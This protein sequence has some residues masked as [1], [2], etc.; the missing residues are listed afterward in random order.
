MALWASAQEYFRT[1]PVSDRIKTLQVGVDGEKLSLPVIPLNGTGAISVQFDEMSH[2]VK[3]YYYSIH[4]CNAD[5]TPSSILDMEA[6]DGVP[7]GL[8][9]DYEPSINTTFLYT[10]YSVKFPNDQVKFKLSGNYRVM[11]FEDNNPDKLVAVA[12]FSVVD[13]KVSVTATVRGNTDVEINRRMQQLDFEI[14]N[15]QFPVKDVFSELK[16]LVR[17]N[18]RYD[19]QVFDVKPSYTTP[20]KQRYVNNPSLIFEGGNEYRSFDC[21][22]VYTFGGGVENIRYFAPYY[23]V[24]LYP[25]APRAGKAYEK[26]SDVNGRYV[27]GVQEYEDDEKTA[28]YMLVHFSIPTEKPFFEGS[29]YLSGDLNY[30]LFDRNVRMEYN[31]QHNAYEQTVLLKQGGYNYMYAFVKKG[32]TS[33]S[34]LPFEGSLWQTSNEYEIYTYYR[35]WGQRYDQ[36]IGVQVVE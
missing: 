29:L 5:W 32:E 15:S 21:S 16:V 34:L 6:V 17:Q 11:I 14:D 8:I 33:G 20:T 27:V 23:H 7:V 18:R 28:D 22:S 10:H 31:A 24:S 2:E 9:S 12:C 4:H 30:N 19:N 25:D 1:M 35:G 36:L 26:L 3:N 13:P